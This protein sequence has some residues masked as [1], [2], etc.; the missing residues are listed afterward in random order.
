ME[1]KSLIVINN[2]HNYKYQDYYYYQQYT[3]LTDTVTD[4][5]NTNINLL[6]YTQSTRSL[7]PAFWWHSVL[8]S[9]SVSVMV[10]ARRVSRI[11]I[12][13]KKINWCQEYQWVL[14]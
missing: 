4:A 7:C 2:K 14:M 8:V 10:Q 12:G 11:S 1:I 5:I 13:V 6:H 9:R 3:P